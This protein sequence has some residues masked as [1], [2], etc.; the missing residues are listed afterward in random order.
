V[1]LQSLTLSKLAN[2]LIPFL[3]SKGDGGL[4]R[5]G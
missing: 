5:I 1:I 4:I 3:P 2:S